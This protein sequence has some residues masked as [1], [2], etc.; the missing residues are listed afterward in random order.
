MAWILKSQIVDNAITEHLQR[1]ELMF[2]VIEW[3]VL[4]WVVLSFIQVVCAAHFQ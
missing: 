2:M 1:R 3:A 4:S